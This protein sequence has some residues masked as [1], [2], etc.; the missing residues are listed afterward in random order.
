MQVLS[1]VYDLEQRSVEPHSCYKNPKG[2]LIL[3]AY[4]TTGLE[5]GWRT[6]KAD[7]I[8]S[9]TATGQ[10]FQRPRGDYKR[11]DPRKPGYTLH[12]EL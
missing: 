10:S 12:C 6:F 9:L 4:Q 2:N 5:P 3:F 8:S 7:K 1:L 11:L